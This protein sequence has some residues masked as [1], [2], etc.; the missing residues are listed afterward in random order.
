MTEHTF[1]QNQTQFTVEQPILQPQ[2][3]VATPEEPP[4]SPSSRRRWVLAVGGIGVL[5]LVGIIWFALSAKPSAPVN[6]DIPLP[7]G[8]VRELSPLERRLEET[9]DQL[10]QANPTTQD[11]PFPPVDAELRIDSAR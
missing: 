11:L 9:K 1:N 2:V 7:Q 5:L 10:R 6:E 4:T 8:V 3:L